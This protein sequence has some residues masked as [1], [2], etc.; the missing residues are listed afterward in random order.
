MMASRIPERNRAGG[1]RLENVSGALLVRRFSVRQ[2]EI[3]RV[4]ETVSAQRLTSIDKAA[5][6]ELAQT[7]MDSEY[8]NLDGDFIQAGC[9]LGGAAIVLAHAKHRRRT[10]QVHDL[11][12]GEANTEI[13]VQQTLASHGADTR[14]NVEVI[15][16]A[17][18]KTLA[19][20][21][22][23]A[24][25][26]V[27]CG[28]YDPMRVLLER[29]VPRL[30]SGAHLIVDDYRKSKECSRAVDEYFRGKSGFEL[31]RKSRLHVIRN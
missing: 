19:A 28:Q 4:I 31:V 22:A 20:E 26:H 27:D 15:P 17:Y 10:L 11:F 23:L 14:L 1:G 13:R 6:C 24:L 3:F 12:T 16:G 29:L 18:E 5:L 9:G 8:E 25:A 30:V 2:P 21:G 7:A